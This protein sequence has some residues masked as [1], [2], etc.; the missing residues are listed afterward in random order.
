MK[1]KAVLICVGIYL[2]SA[3]LLIIFG[4]DP[5]TTIRREV[6]LKVSP[7][8]NCISKALTTIPGS[9]DFTQHAKG[10]SKHSPPADVVDF[11]VDRTWLRIVVERDVDRSRFAIEI[12]EI[13]SGLEREELLRRRALIKEVY[14]AVHSRCAGLPGWE[15]LQESCINVDCSER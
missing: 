6:E 15:E 9:G 11:E 7:D 1:K 5:A 14:S 10:R 13:G 4:G 8:I 12:S 3:V 2:L